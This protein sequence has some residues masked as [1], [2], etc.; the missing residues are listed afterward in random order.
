[1]CIIIELIITCYTVFYCWR[2][3]HTILSILVQ[4][5]WPFDPEECVEREGPNNGEEETNTNHEELAHL[6]GGDSVGLVQYHE[7]GARHQDHESGCE[8]FH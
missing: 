8:T 7:A 4:V 6:G 5:A 2:N 1:M 3:R